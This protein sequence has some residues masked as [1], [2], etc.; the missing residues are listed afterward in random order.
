MSVNKLVMKQVAAA[1]LVSAALL[2]GTLL[3][4]STAEAQSGR[5]P[6]DQPVE[7]KTDAQQSAD[8][9]TAQDSSQAAKSGK[10]EPTIKISTN[11][12]N[13]EAS[14]LYKKTGRLVTGL[15]KKNFTLYEDGVKQEITNF[16]LGEGPATVVLLL[17]NS[18]K[19][20]IWR[21]FMSPTFREEIFRSAAGF[22]DMFMKK[23][24]FASVVTFSMRPK[25]IQ[26]FT[27]DPGRVMQALQAAYRDFI[28]FSESNIF[29]ALAFT[30]E[31]GKAVQLYAED[32]GESHYIGLDEIEGHCAIVLITTGIDTFSRITYDKAMK[33]VAG[34]GVPVFPIGVGNLYFKQYGDMMP[35]TQR[36]NWL[37]A[38][39]EMK[40]FAKLSG[41]SYFPMTFEGEIPS[42]MQS[43][44][45]LLRTQYS[46][47]YVPSNTR[48]EGKERNIK[49]EVDPEGSGQPDTKNIEV[50]YREKY[51]EPGG[52]N[53]TGNKTAA[54]GKAQ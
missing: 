32:A 54:A 39:N 24:D 29:D 17:D 19:N 21:G 31:G 9:P 18:N 10:D 51:V 36:M 14:V 42:I 8:V 46:I 20:A 28:N 48:Q 50:R 2:S 43:I 35:A 1:L 49:L 22:V 52:G 33:I 6:P 25:L 37:Q 11:V 30:L 27:G 7:K 26:D 3:P 15:T 53:K 45:A 34:A 23:G 16:S 40:T 38:E 12:V 47:G 13:V 5:K 44:A 4:R 41:G